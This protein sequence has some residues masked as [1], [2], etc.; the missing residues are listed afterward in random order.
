M[1]RNPGLTHAG[2]FLQFIHRK[3][4]VLQQRDDAQAGG[5][6]QC[7]EG[8]EGG[9]HLARDELDAMLHISCVPVL[10]NYHA[11]FSANAFSSVLGAINFGD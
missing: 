4:V 11:N 2:D 9:A 1:R 10:F 6:G 7:P 3:F 8:F 5:I